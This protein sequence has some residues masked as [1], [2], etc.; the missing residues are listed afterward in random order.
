MC[1]AVP[2]KELPT[3]RGSRRTYG[4]GERVQLSCVT[5]ASRPAPT[6]KW[7]INDIPVPESYSMPA[8]GRQS[9]SLPSAS[10]GNQRAGHDD[11][12]R[13]SMNQTDNASAFGRNLSSLEA[14]RLQVSKPNKPQRTISRL[15]F[16]LSREHLTRGHRFSVRCIAYMQTDF[17]PQ[18]RV[19]TQTRSLIKPLDRHRFD[20]TQD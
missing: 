15:D 18:G 19:L 8:S 1:L 5:G 17:Y 4:L 20:R 7:L 12:E 6:V 13:Q 9:G 3:I 11:S 10:G 16:V 2:A 14:S